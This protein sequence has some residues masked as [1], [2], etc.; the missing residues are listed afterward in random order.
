LQFRETNGEWELRSSELSSRKEMVKNASFS[1][2][3]LTLT[4]ARHSATHEAIVVIPA[5]GRYPG[6]EYVSLI[7]NPGGLQLMQDVL[8]FLH[9]ESGAVLKSVN[10]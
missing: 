1:Y 6:L 3:E 8:Q 2:V 9:T 4:L 10:S 5:L 7:T